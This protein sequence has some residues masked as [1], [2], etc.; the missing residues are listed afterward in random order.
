MTIPLDHPWLVDVHEQITTLLQSDSPSLQ[1]VIDHFLQRKGKLIRSLLVLH[2]GTLLGAQK[3]P[4]IDAA[5]LMEIIHMASLVHDDV[6]DQSPMRRGV[7]TIH[8]V[9][10]TG[11]AVLLGDYFFATMLRIAAQYPVWMTDIADVIHSLVQGEFHQMDDRNRLSTTPARYLQRISEKTAHFMG[12]SCK[13]AG[14]VS[15][16]DAPTLRQLETFGKSLG[17]AYQLVDDLQ[18]LKGPMGTSY[19][20]KPN[21]QDLPQ[22]NISLPL[23]HAYQRLQRDFTHTNTDEIRQVLRETH[24]IEYTGKIA[25]DFLESAQ[26]IL[27]VFPENP[28]KIGLYH[29]IYKIESQLQG[30][31]SSK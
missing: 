5:T 16:C 4:L 8:T 19:D 7:A 25:R 20:G 24:S 13:I 27:L 3:K 10:D 18:D 12:I 28:G 30:V 6:I 21:W 22:G 17:M 9:W 14:L 26:K 29:V 2:T 23:L 1:R 31:V 11:A 15:Q